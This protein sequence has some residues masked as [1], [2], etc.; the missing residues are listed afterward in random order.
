MQNQLG[1]I[2]HVSQRVAIALNSWVIQAPVCS[3]VN[4]L[5]SVS[6][7]KPLNQK[8][9]TKIYNPVLYYHRI[10]IYNFETD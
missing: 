2:L 7:T 1:C 10:I 3:L 6:H 5:S 8:N 9:S 4:Q